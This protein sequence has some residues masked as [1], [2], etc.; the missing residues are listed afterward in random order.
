MHH[1]SNKVSLNLGRD[2]ID[3][4]DWMKNKKTTVKPKK[5]YNFF[6]YAVKFGLNCDNIVGDLGRII[7]KEYFMIFYN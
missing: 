4:P 1:K 3:S 2:Y 6:Q 7:Y 5:G